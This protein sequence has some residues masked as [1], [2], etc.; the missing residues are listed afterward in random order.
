[1]KKEEIEKIVAN[2]LARNPPRPDAPVAYKA[3]TD[4]KMHFANILNDLNAHT[5]GPILGHDDPY[6]DRTS[7]DAFLIASMRHV[8]KD[9]PEQLAEFDKWEK[10]AFV[11]CFD[12][13]TKQAESR[14]SFYVHSFVQEFAAK[15]NIEIPIKEW[16]QASEMAYIN[17]VKE[18]I[19]NNQGRLS[20]YMVTEVANLIDAIGITKIEDE[21]RQFYQEMG[22]AWGHAIA[23]SAITPLDPTAAEAIYLL[24]QDMRWEEYKDFISANVKHGKIEALSQNPELW[25]QAINQETSSATYITGD[26]VNDVLEMMEHVPGEIVC[27][28]MDPVQFFRKCGEYMPSA[29]AAAQNPFN[30]AYLESSQFLSSINNAKESPVFGQFIAE[31]VEL[32]KNQQS[33]TFESKNPSFD[34]STEIAMDC[35]EQIL[36]RG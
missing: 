36:D 4:Y 3:I 26:M 24:R 2:D 17:D 29:E 21:A 23:N 11:E 5:M 18:S 10:E 20:P 33:I 19:K 6:A 32:G 13:I 1:M 34:A 7:Y 31:C 22:K 30:E 16:Q 27:Q 8:F 15:H 25:V 9:N 12:K 14:Y 35:D 28:N